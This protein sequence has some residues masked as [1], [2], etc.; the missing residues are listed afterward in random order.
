MKTNVLTFALVLMSLT[1]NAQQ[2]AKT[3][4]ITPKAGVT[5]SSFSGN[6]P[7]TISY[8]IIPEGHYNMYYDGIY[9]SQPVDE[10][11][12]IRAGAMGF[13]DIKNK[14][15]F[16]IGAE[17]QYQFTSVVGLSLGAFYTQE[18]AAY[19]TKGHYSDFDG[20]KVSIKD[21]LKIHL[22]CITV[23]VLANVYVWKGLALKAGLQPEFAIGKKTKGDVTID[24]E[25]QAF[26]A[27]SSDADIKSFSLSLP[28]GISYE[29]K[30]VVADLRYSFGLTD[31]HK[32]KDADIGGNSSAHNR[33][34]T[35]TLGYKFP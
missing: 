3:F 4:S 26:K 33:V 2:K 12:L 21:D 29:Y 11:T 24:F 8:V 31:L 6:M 22:N 34:L 19:N 23:P 13:G 17:G 7:A 35:F 28:I 5:A 30:H 20:V 10:S 14:V 9:G 32:N 27:V 25:R 1:A 18:G 16:T 15:G